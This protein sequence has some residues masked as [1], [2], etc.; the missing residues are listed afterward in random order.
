MG[1]LKKQLDNQKNQE[2]SGSGDEEIK[3]LESVSKKLEHIYGM[4]GFKDLLKRPDL[5][6]DL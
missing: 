3:Q 1:T 2:Q 4:Q 5:F 6:T